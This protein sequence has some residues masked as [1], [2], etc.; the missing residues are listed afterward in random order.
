MCWLAAP[1]A[2]LFGFPEDSPA[3]WLGGL[4]AFSAV[5]LLPGLLL[6]SRFSARG[7]EDNAVGEMEAAL[8]LPAVAFAVSL[9]LL[10]LLALPFQVLGGGP[11]LAL[12]FLGLISAMLACLPAGNAS[13]YQPAKRASMSEMLFLLSGSGAVLVAVAIT[14][15]GETLSP[16]SLWAFARAQHDVATRAYPAVDAVLGASMAPLRM[17]NDAWVVGLGAWATLSE[18]SRWILFER[19]A[20]VAITALAASAGLGLARTVFPPG[21][22]SLAAVLGLATAFV[23]RIP[24]AQIG[25]MALPQ[26]MAEDTI[27]AALV[28]LPV[29]VGA[30]VT[31]T[32]EQRRAHVAPWP[33]L[34]YTMVAL[35]A[36]DAAAAQ[37]A[38]IATL[39]LSFA[40]VTS[41]RRFLGSAAAATFVV[42]T[43]ACAGLPVLWEAGQRADLVQSNQHASTITGATQQPRSVQRSVD[44]GSTTVEIEVAMEAPSRSDAFPPSPR[45]RQGRNFADLGGMGATMHPSNVADPILILALAGIAI[46]LI[47]RSR[48]SSRILLSLSLPALALAYTPGLADLWIR[49]AT[50]WRATTVFWILPAGSLVA[51]FLARAPKILAERP[52]S[53]RWITLASWTL[54]ALAALPSLPFERLLLEGARQT[55]RGPGED[56]DLRGLFAELQTLPRN[57]LLAAAPGLAPLIPAFSGLPVLSNGATGTLVFSRNPSEATARL[58]ANTHLTALPSGSSAL[59]SQ[60]A[61]TWGV[62]HVVLENADCDGPL[63]ERKRIGRLR[64]CQV[65]D[66]AVPGPEAEEESNP[67]LADPRS[68]D[69]ADLLAV[70]QKDWTCAPRHNGV[71]VDGSRLWKVRER[72]SA[73]ALRID[74][75]IALLPASD[76]VALALQ[77]GVQ[78]MPSQLVYRLEAYGGSPSFAESS[79][80]LSPD[81]SGNSYL[82]VPAVGASSLRLVLATANSSLRIQDIRLYGH[83]LAGDDE[84]NTIKK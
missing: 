69:G 76:P 35:V 40:A 12:V 51:Y 66:Q 7:S 34:F 53:Q 26:G 72:W 9:G 46:A 80:V 10:F 43:L 73:A 30:V 11:Q 77:T 36:T 54:V 74:C 25:N 32:F 37:A 84:G 68:L 22:A 47:E 16:A 63:L 45:S 42:A 3:A 57:A 41:G 64:L 19:L 38:L 62:T 79:G 59:R 5:F 44:L 18:A 4:G 27:V 52:A 14:A 24:S 28:L 2:S 15:G 20:P 8:S 55:S 60:A 1:G 65:A 39:G 70:M 83:A 31:T 33:V 58:V 50:P 71:G 29:V 13:D 82:D 49:W 67:S 81:D 17:T 48:R 78:P 56:P 21:W 75:G 23:T 61:E 6:V